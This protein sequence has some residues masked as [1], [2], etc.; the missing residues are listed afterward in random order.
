MRLVTSK[1]VCERSRSALDMKNPD[2]IYCI[3][4]F[5]CITF[6]DLHSDFS[7]PILH[8]GKL[9]PRLCSGV[10]LGLIPQ[11]VLISQSCPD[12]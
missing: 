12:V 2:S 5:N 8:N 3:R 4:H 10:C 9:K 6:F 7:I 11:S 1:P